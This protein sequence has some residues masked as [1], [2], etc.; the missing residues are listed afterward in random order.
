MIA[1]QGIPHCDESNPDN[2]RELICVMDMS[3]APFKLTLDVAYPSSRG[4]LRRMLENF[5]LDSLTETQK[6]FLL[7]R[8]WTKLHCKLLAI[9][10]GPYELA[11]MVYPVLLDATGQP[12]PWMRDAQKTK[13]DMFVGGLSNISTVHILHFSKP[14]TYQAGID[15]V[16]QCDANNAKLD[17]MHQKRNTH[18]TDRCH[19]TEQ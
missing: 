15:F 2:M 6:V 1:A 7:P 5:S 9:K 8:R 14:T 10:Q 4:P 12:I 18:T 16:N 13:L 3:K 11:D 17:I 19:R